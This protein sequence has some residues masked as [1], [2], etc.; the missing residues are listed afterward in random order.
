MVGEEQLKINRE[1]HIFDHMST[2]GFTLVVPEN[3]LPPDVEDGTI[4]VTCCLLTGDSFHFPD[5]TEPVSALYHITST[6]SLCEPITL[7]IEHCSSQPGDS[8][9]VRADDSNRMFHYIS[10][11]VEITETR[12][13][14]GLVNFSWLAVIAAKLGR[15]R[16]CGVLYHKESSLVKQYY[17]FVV[18]RNLHALT[19][20][21]TILS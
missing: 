7:E 11:N 13:K 10:S 1:A 4:T 21:S 6:C 15:R 3:C 18:F 14:V 5:D 16:Y 12:A 8:I 19:E 2:L 17:N 20:V 9:F